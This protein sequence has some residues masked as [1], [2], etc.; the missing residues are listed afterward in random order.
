MTPA[1]VAGSDGLERRT[2][3]VPWG[4]EVQTW[5]LIETRTFPREA[6]KLP[7]ATLF[8]W[9]DPPGSVPAAQSEDE[10]TLENLVDEPTVEIDGEPEAS[11]PPTCGSREPT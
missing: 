10:K 3:V 4:I 6:A 9:G 2:R 8:A 11:G 7:L 1:A 5:R